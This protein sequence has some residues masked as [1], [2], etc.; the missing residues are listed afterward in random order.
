M[1]GIRAYRMCRFIPAPAGNI[2]SFLHSRPAH[3]VHPRTRGEHGIP[4]LNPLKPTGS[5]PHPRG[6]YSER[7]RHYTERRFIPAPAGNIRLVMSAD[8]SPPVHP[9]TRGEHRFLSLNAWSK[10]GSSPHPR[11][12]ST[13]T[14]TATVLNRFIPAPAGNIFFKAIW[15]VF[16]SVHPRTRGEHL[17][18][19]ISQPDKC[20]SSPHP[21]G[22]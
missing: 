22:T 4:P 11:G 18:I 2:D 20:G 21:R 1:L 5:S 16:N 8:N 19:G 15:S 13:P 6:T 17:Y 12:T 7:S 9:R 3:A 10:P 14:P